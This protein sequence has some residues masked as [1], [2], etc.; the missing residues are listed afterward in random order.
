MGEIELYDLHYEYTHHL[1][2]APRLAY[3][4]SIVRPLTSLVKLMIHMNASIGNTNIP[5]TDKFHTHSLLMFRAATNFSGELSWDDL[6]KVD[7]ARWR[8]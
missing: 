5:P 3:N 2:E 8:Y 7:W 1:S 4:T 6:A